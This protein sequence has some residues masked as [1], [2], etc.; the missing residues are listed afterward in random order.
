MRLDVKPVARGEQRRSWPLVAGG[1][2][3]ALLLAGAGLSGWRYVKRAAV[4]APAPQAVTVVVPR[5]ASM[6]IAVPAPAMP[7][8]GVRQPSGARVLPGALNGQARPEPA[9]IKPQKDKPAGT[10]PA[11]ARPAL[12]KAR[13]A[14]APVGG[15]AALAAARAS[16]MPAPAG[17]ASSAG[18]E[19]TVQQRAENDYRRALASLQE[20]RVTEAI[21]SLERS[22]GID[23]RHEAARQT[24]V[25]LLLENKRYDEAIGQI[26][27]GLA[28]EPR[29]PSLAMLLA[30]LQIERGGS[31]IDTLMRTLPYA[32]G[33]GDYHA[34]LAGALQRQ[35]RHR[36]ASEQYQ[37]ALRAAP[38]NGVWLM[39]LGMSLLAEKRNAE[40][41]A[42]LRAARDSGGLSAELSGLVER[43]LQQLSP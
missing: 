36:E 32:A 17:V 39:G 31:G 35:Q 26:E 13:A 22:L 33:N 19:L 5:A 38:R 24:L 34:F 2:A 4:A 23:P 20:G 40:A 1:L 8:G 25:G 12:A 28:I 42:A 15:Q 11:E 41:L 9:A 21:G 6:A 10:V 18:R 27:A 3:M 37:A 29:Q 43:K 7:D 30:R 16:A 14:I